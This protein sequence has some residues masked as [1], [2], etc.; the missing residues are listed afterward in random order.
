MI[1]GDT[2][3]DSPVLETEK[4]LKDFIEPI[5]LIFVL[6]DIILLVIS[7]FF[8]LSPKI[9]NQVFI[10]DLFV[11][12][13]LLIEFS[14]NFYKA[15]DRKTFFKEHWFELISSIPFD[16]FLLRTLRFVRFIRVIKFIRLTKVITLFKT[17]SHLLEHYLERSNLGRLGVTIIAIV[18]FS[19]LI[20][21]LLDPNM[22]DLLISLWFVVSTVTSVG[23][24]D[25]TPS[26][27][28]GRLLGIFLIIIGYVILSIFIGSISSFYQEKLMDNVESIDDDMIITKNNTE[29][30]LE[31]V[32]KQNNKIENLEKEVDNLKSLIEK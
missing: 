26:T 30:L 12:I 13:L 17:D 10:F 16:F 8:S 19:S 29:K 21:F 9:E 28:I 22:D 31:L 27:T 20:L 11:C 5:L 15:D 7:T 23:Y 6:F 24:G 1:Q 2:M 14:Y 32:Q 25:V 3:A 18:L 4:S